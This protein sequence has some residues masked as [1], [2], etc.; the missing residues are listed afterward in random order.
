MQKNHAKP[1][2]IGIDEAGRGPLAG[3]VVV[4]ALTILH[5][6]KFQLFGS[7]NS[8]ELSEKRRDE[9]YDILRNH[10]DV[11]FATSRISAPQIDQLNIYEATRFAMRKALY[12][13]LP[14]LKNREL[15]IEQILIDGNMPI[16]TRMPQKTIIKADETVPVCMLASIV[17]KVTRDRLMRRYHKQ[18][19][20]YLFEKHKGY[21]TK[22][23]V[24]LLRKYGPTPLH[25][26]TFKPLAE[27]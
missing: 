14:E 25:R 5:P 3:P 12:N 13:L 24:E 27:L 2:V 11:F 20:Q 22:L 10:P 7:F 21:G 18:Y 17:A 23:H 1:V 26:K 19:P 6:E 15:F 8:K 4:A 9:I 16:H